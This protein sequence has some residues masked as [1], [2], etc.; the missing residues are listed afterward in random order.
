MTMEANGELH[1]T[2]A[3]VLRREIHG[4]GSTVL[5]AVQEIKTSIEDKLGEQAEEIGKILGEMGD[6]KRDV[7]DVR[8]ILGLENRS[9]P[10]PPNFVPPSDRP[11]IPVQ[12]ESENG[13]EVTDTGTYRIM[14]GTLDRISKRLSD[15][16]QEK[17][18]AE[19]E[20]V[21][22]EK[23]RKELAEKNERLTGQVKLAIVLAGAVATMVTTI[24]AI[25]EWSIR[26][27]R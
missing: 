4:I 5:R 14:P 12:F 18:T 21:G 24:V 7:R 16:E 26:H 1:S 13:I 19:A 6:V 22:K 9:R 8:R 25:I 20:A 10:K 15:M 23:L 27:V 2:E 17:Q 11:S 3:I